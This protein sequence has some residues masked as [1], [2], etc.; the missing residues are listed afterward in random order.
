MPLFV[1]TVSVYSTTTLCSIFFTEIKIEFLRVWSRILFVGFKFIFTPGYVVKQ[2]DLYMHA[3]K[4]FRN[5]NSENI[6]EPS[7][8]DY[9]SDFFSILVRIF[10]PYISHAINTSAFFS[11]LDFSLIETNFIIH[12]YLNSILFTFTKDI[13]KIMFLGYFFLSPLSSIRLF[14]Y[15][16]HQFLSTFPSLIYTSR[17]QKS[18]NLGSMCTEL[19]INNEMMKYYCK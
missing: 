1:A 9:I 15:N 19:L 4:T 10:S 11:F 13:G 16:S 3:W 7:G 5:L 8:S 18:L 12:M 17:L 2:V 14:V 6:E